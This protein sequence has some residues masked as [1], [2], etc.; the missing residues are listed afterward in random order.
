MVNVQSDLVF[1]FGLLS[2][3]R[4]GLVSLALENVV[5]FTKTRFYQKVNEAVK[6][7]VTMW[8]R[9]TPTLTTVWHKSFL[10]DIF[11]IENIFEAL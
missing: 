8:K 6:L 10:Q 7:C 9:S 2:E 5:S 1:I 4:I 11:L 3:S